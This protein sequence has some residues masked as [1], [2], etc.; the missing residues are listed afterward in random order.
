MFFES[1]SQDDSPDIR[2][3]SFRNSLHGPEDG[4]AIFLLDGII[5]E[6]RAEEIV[7]EE[8]PAALRPPEISMSLR[9]TRSG[10]LLNSNISP[11]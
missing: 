3:A 9:S 2:A 5:S 8:N 4:N 1:G 6:Y 10:P 11:F 7:G